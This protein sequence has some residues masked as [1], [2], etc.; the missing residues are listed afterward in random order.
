M[1]RPT[2][3]P[4]YLEFRDRHGIRRART[5]ISFGGGEVEEI[6]LGVYGT[7]ESRAKYRQILDEWEAAQAAGSVGNLVLTVADLCAKFLVHA[8]QHYQHPSGKPTGELNEFIAA[9]RPLLAR[10]GD[11]PARDF[12]PVALKKI[13]EGMVAAE[14]SRQ[15]INQ[16]IGRI[17]RAFKWA[18]S[19]QLVPVA[20]FQGLS[21]VAGLAR[22][23]TAAPD[24]REVPPADMSAVCRAARFLTRTLR[25]MLHVQLLTGMRPQDVCGLTGAEIDRPGVVLDSVQIWVYR[26]TQHK[27]RWRGHSKAIA[28]GPRAQRLLRP[29]LDAAGDGPLFTPSRKGAKPYTTAGYDRRIAE[30][31]VKAGVKFHA[32]QLRHSA[33]TTIQRE[34]D[35]DAARAT[36]G[37]RDAQITTRYADRDL[38]RAAEVA[39][40]LG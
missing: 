5:R 28:I 36:L 29:F 34:F 2:K 9:F 40:R 27:T 1:A 12:G 3:G 10:Y 8:K 23:R 37:H 18:A 16:R 35:L 32:N 19:E 11:S 24:N 4:Q 17:R 20:V 21:T 25:A 7:P 39:K 31:C 33:A 13:R 22:G 14:L 38:K 6:Q 30:A 15:T 26:P